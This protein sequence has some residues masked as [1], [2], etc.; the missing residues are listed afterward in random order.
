MNTRFTNVGRNLSR[1]ALS[2]VA[3][4][5]LMNGD[6]LG[7]APQE[8]EPLPFVSPMFGDNMVLQRGKPNPVWGWSEPGDVVRVEIGEHS[9]MA[10]AGPD[11]KWQTQIQ[12]PPAGGPYTVKIT[13][14]QDVELREVLVGDVWLCA[15]QSNMQ[16]PLQAARNGAEE[17][18]AAEHPEIR[19]FVVGQR[20]A[21]A[22]VA[23]PRGT[24]KIVSPSTLSASRFGGISAVAYFFARKLQESV[25]VPIGLVQDAVGGVPAETFVSAEGLRPLKD[26]DADI[27]FSRP[28]ARHL[29]APLRSHGWRPGGQGGQ[30]GRV[31]IGR[32]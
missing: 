19:Y 15:G 25:N 27:V 29:E 14:R 5:T 8:T 1:L 28:P 20:A 23:V 11:A 4:L 12:P 9:A 22:P 18:K 7:A 10:T 16:F 3:A 17:V 30:T 6:A 24:W 13:G 21:Y 26:F 2:V 31:F 32:R